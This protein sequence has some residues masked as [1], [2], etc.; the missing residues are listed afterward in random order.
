MSRFLSLSALAAVL[1][2]LSPLHAA[3]SSVQYLI[4]VTYDMVITRPSTPSSTVKNGI[5]TEKSAYSFEVFTSKDLLK[6]ML[7]GKTDAELKTWALYAVSDSASFGGETEP[8]GFESIRL[9]ARKKNDTA[10]LSEL[11]AGLTFSL[12]LSDTRSYSSTTVHDNEEEGPVLSKRETLTQLATL[13]Q[14][15]PARGTR[16]AGT[17][18]TEGQLSHGLIYGKITIAGETTSGP[19]NCPTAATYRAAGTFE[20]VPGSVANESGLAEVLISFGTPIRKAVASD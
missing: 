17:L 14:S 5:T 2:T 19:V 4:P 16:P 15:L 20:A 6:L 18:T 13:T 8:N 1:A 12:S 10:P 7:P 3:L 9:V 11:P